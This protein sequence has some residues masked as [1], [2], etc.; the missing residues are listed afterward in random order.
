[1]P[2]ADDLSFLRFFLT[3]P[4]YLLPE[5]EA[6]R[7]TEEKEV[8][9][10]NA[11]ILDE[12]QSSGQ[13]SQ[14]SSSGLSL[15]ETAEDNKK[16]VLL[17]FYD[18]KSEGLDSESK[19]LLE[20]IL[21]AIN[22]SLEDIALCNWAPLE[23]IFEQQKTVFETLQKLNSNKILAFGDLPLAW[24]LS[25]FFQKYHITQDAEGRKLL[26]A[27]DLLKIEQNREL[28]IQLWSALQKMF[29]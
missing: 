7:I 5:T 3:E 11:I 6:V 20:K 1:M 15:P 14:P 9:E 25:H 28:K 19:Q 23:A 26:L 16:G 24:S 12:E 29:Q 8:L 21:K 22:L 13:D 18:K 17:L 2:T 10:V 4:I 27:D